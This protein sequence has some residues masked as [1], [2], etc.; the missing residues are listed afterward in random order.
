[1]AHTSNVYVSDHSEPVLRFHNLRTAAN[2]AAYLLDSILPNM[3][4]CDI[5]CGPGTITT[6][7]ATLVPDGQVV[8]IDMGQ[9]VIETARSMAAER[10]LKNARF[11]VGD[12]HALGFPDHTFDIVHSHQVLHHLADPVSALREWRRVT[13]P[14]GIVACRESD[15]ESGTHYPEIKAVTS[16]K[17]V[18]MKTVRSR[19]GEPNGGRHL[20]AW[21]RKSG[22]DVRIFRALVSLLNQNGVQ[23]YMY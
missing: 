1:M 19:G 4:I 11:Q 6:D 3:Q 8:G 5:G 13:R 21:A 12:A 22:I 15:F 20:I 23:R 16:F 9:D 18:Y 14:G 17:D 7:L 2:S 10:G